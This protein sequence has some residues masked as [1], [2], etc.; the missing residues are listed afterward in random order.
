MIFC[1]GGTHILDSSR[2]VKILQKLQ[3]FIMII[4]FKGL[5][6][7]GL[8]APAVVVC[9][10]ATKLNLPFLSAALVPPAPVLDS[11]GLD[12]VLP[13]VVVYSVVLLNPADYS[14]RRLQG[15]APE[16]QALE[17]EQPVSEQVPE[18]QLLVAA[19]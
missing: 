4:S 15:L 13:L 11:E 2:T 14:V 18:L 12:Q 16:Q 1:G 19:G 7:L 5:E 17:P 6:D 9:S 8:P 10:V 3:L